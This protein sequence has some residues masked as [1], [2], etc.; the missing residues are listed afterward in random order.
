MANFRD[1]VAN[2]DINARQI[3][4]S[5]SKTNAERVGHPTQKPL[6]VMKWCI[7]QVK[8]DVK[9][10]VDPFMGSGT[11]L[12]AAKASGITAVGIDLDE[13]YCE[14]AASRSLKRL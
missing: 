6:A 5:I 7:S 1:G 9:T 10:L 8:R 2:L 14:K 12:V 4:Q 13:E 3:S 11:S